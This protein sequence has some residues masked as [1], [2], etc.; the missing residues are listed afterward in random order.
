MPRF[1]GRLGRNHGLLPCAVP[2]AYMAFGSALDKSVDPTLTL[3]PSL[4]FADL[5]GPCVDPGGI[6]EDPR[7]HAAGLGDVCLR[8]LFRHVHLPPVPLLLRGSW[9]WQQLLGHLG[10]HLPGDSSAVLPQ[11]C[12]AGSL[13]DL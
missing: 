7:L 12:S 1:K 8:V 9:R 6:L 4:I 11:C 13:H 3:P 10:C 5:W 2:E